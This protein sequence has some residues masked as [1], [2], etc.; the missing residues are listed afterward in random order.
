MV[1]T[2]PLLASGNPIQRA[3]DGLIAKEPVKARAYD[4]AEGPI[5]IRNV[6]Q[7][8]PCIFPAR[9]RQDIA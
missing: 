6:A 4:D 2:R 8:I 7:S 1:E 3:H 9:I 5:D